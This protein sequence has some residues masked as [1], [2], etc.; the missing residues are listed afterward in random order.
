MRAL[1]LIQAGQ[2]VN[3]GT[4]QVL[5]A[6]TPFDELRRL[7]LSA[8]TERLVRHT[9][10]QSVGLLVAREVQPGSLSEGLIEPGD[11]LLQMNGHLVT[12]FLTL[13]AML[14]EA[15]QQSVTLDVLRGGKALSL[16]VPVTDLHAI[17]PA[18]YIEFGAAV[19]HALSYQ[20]A[21]HFNVPIRG[22]F[23][24]SPGY[25]LGS[26]GVPRGAVLTSVNGK[27]VVT[28]DDFEG[29]LDSLADGARATVRFITLE[30][31]RRIQTRVMRMDRQ[32]YPLQRCHRDDALGYWPCHSLAS[33]PAAIPLQP[34]TAS[35]SPSGDPRADALAPS[36]V[37]VDF[38]IPYA[39]SGVVQASYQG[40]G[41]I[42]DAARGLLVADRNTVPVALGEVRLTFGGVVEIP[43]HVEYV[44]PLHNLVVVSYD[45]RLIGATPVK[46]VTFSNRELKSG[47]D[48]WVVG[49]RPDLKVIS[50]QAKV[51]GS[52]VT[53][54][55]AAR[56]FAFREA[57]LETIT[58]IDGP[59]NFDG[60]ITDRTGAVRALWS[61]F[62]Y[63]SGHDVQQENLGI[64]SDVVMEMAAAVRSSLPLRSLEIEAQVVSLSVGRSLG[65]SEEWV[66]KIVAHSPSHRQLL[67]VNRLIAGSPAAA[68]LQPGDLLLSINGQV[69]TRLR[70]LEL[71]SQVPVATVMVWRNGA[72]Q[73]LV[74]STVVPNSV[75]VNRV[76]LWAG[77][78][79]ETPYRALSSQRGIAPEGVFVSSF[80]YG[81]PATRYGLWSGRRIVAV[82][83]QST[84]DLDSFL[85]AV[86]GR[87]DRTSLRLKTLT[88]NN[89]VEVITLKLDNKYW[90]TYELTR[91]AS[92]W[93]RQSLE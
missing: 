92:G 34:A 91:T 70:E 39:V 42:I 60:V 72:E 17:T 59:N 45:P 8:E 13:E 10:A 74:M 23:V 3:R 32:W 77:A 25:A 58:L 47:E 90:P 44:H 29:T 88:W 37:S 12:D 75:G 49:L 40:T 85:A 48:V 83:D 79:L 82:D 9:Q 30:E 53:Q 62:A 87:E 38:Q 63:D 19:V 6:Y 21:R 71:S 66:K 56:T 14:D 20:E 57:S 18:E 81:S 43:G 7:G 4:L 24:A 41:V 55:P 64:P 11:I 2:P 54:L 68:C 89:A 28:L 80:I 61:S 35:Y 76:V 5:F 36:L 84:L 27:A 73:T 1:S 50:Q 86:R 15:V 33:G 93:Q 31:P 51:S 26:A 16:R 78:T 46:A 69:V 67:A 65:L 22:V 52:Q